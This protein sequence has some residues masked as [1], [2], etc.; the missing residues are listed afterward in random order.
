MLMAS[1]DVVLPSSGYYPCAVG[2]VTAGDVFPPGSA[3]P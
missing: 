3:L 1:P 2:W